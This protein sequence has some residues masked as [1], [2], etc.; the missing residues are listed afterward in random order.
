MK[1]LPDWQNLDVLH[2]G[3][4]EP[5][6][7]LIPYTCERAAIAGDRGASD[8][9]RLLNGEWDFCY[10]DKGVAPEGFQ[11]PDYELDAGWDTLPVPANWQMH[12][13]DIPQYANVNYPIP[14]DPPY[15]PDE[16]PV[17][18]Y[19]RWFTLPEGWSN[20]QVFLNFDGVNSAFYVWI[21]GS[22]VG[23]S[24]VAHMPAE[25]DITS[26]LVNGENLIAVMV[27]KW[28]DGSYLE[29]QDFWRLS[30]IFRDVYL[31]GA[32]KTHIRNLVAHAELDDTYTNGS[33]KLD[34]QAVNYGDKPAELTLKTKLLYK[35]RAV[36][37][38]EAPLPLTTDGPTALSLCIDVPGCKKWTAETPELYLL[39]AELWQDDQLIEVQRVDIGFRRVEIRDR[40]LFVNGVSIKIKGVNR[41]DTHSELGHVTPMEALLKDIELMKQNNVNTVR[42]SHY[43]ND[44]RWLELCDRY[45]LYVVDETDL[46]C[47]G[48]AMQSPTGYDA[49]AVNI[50][51]DDSKWEKAYV[52]RAE[53]MVCRDVNHPSI[54]I[55]SL[56]NES[57]YGCNHQAMRARILE[58]DASRP[59]HYEGEWAN[60]KMDEAHEWVSDIKSRMYPA[61]ETLAEEGVRPVE[62]DHRPYF[63]C[64][65]GHAMG[66]GPGSLKEYWD[67]IY[68]HDRLIGGCIWEW[69]D[70][71]ILTETEDGEAYYAYGGDFG[72]HP[73]DGCFCVDALNYPDRTP[74]TGLI[75]LKA[76]YAPV[77]FERVGANEIKI[78]NLFAF[79]TLDHLDAAWSLVCEGEQLACG[80]LDLS[81]VA[82][83]G[84]KVVKIDFE[85][86]ESGES[87]IEIRVNEAF[88]TLYCER[89][90][91]VASAQLMLDT[92]PEIYRI[93]AAAMGTLSMDEDDTHVEL[94]GEDFSV[95]FEKDTGRLVSW[96]SAGNEL[97]EK[98]P[99]VNLFRAYIDND[100][101]IRKSWDMLDLTRLLARVEN[102]HIERLNES[103][104]RIAVKRVYSPKIYAPILRAT[105]TYT[106]YGNGSIRLNTIF[107]PLRE[108]PYLP[109]VG[110]QL[111]M[112]AQFD[113]VLWYG[114]GPHENYPD[115][116]VSALLGQ[117]TAMVDDLHE[118]YVRPQ[119]NGARGG[120]RA[121]AVTDILGAGLMVVGEE[122]FE[123][124]G[125]SFSAHPYSDVA[126]HKATHTPELHAE[127][128]TVLS[129][130][131]RMGGVGSNS[132]GPEPQEK[133][134]LR[135]TE[136]ASFTLVLSP[137]NRQMGEMMNFAR[138]LPE[139][140]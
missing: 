69:V 18:C 42:T 60:K 78:R 66:L 86:P 112:P 139:N 90:H 36:K 98:G 2:I 11:L 118:P 1:Q 102:F 35:N 65:Y 43:P 127:E 107:E 39:L 56:G 50:L 75:E 77:R 113:R 17:G 89:G 25:F 70:H 94:L 129:L 45:G 62:E 51:S 38:T 81:G 85:M 57:G 68:A 115:L 37:E 24:K 131:W 20:R 28:S 122:T 87:F 83:Y 72:E 64:E 22:F 121:L 55:W 47:H 12:G 71:G 46:E 111:T 33:L 140:N 135:L 82:P 4:E 123:G 80:R 91:E 31:L 40:Q 92:K 104:V 44:P 19:R 114:K 16:N 76:I 119:E 53:R 10:A 13:Y 67:V 105:M 128:R 120:V 133:Y 97:I 30:G 106:V 132:C 84:E 117:Y 93:P 126:L 103:A 88:D 137:Y 136:K 109:R 7:S 63:M 116:G 21:N 108:L 52:D 125:F 49:G 5:R 95:L 73:H 34:V 9:Y 74:H 14:F 61:V 59:I 130:D 96:L 138:I 110:L 58:L 99:D 23:F 3:R 41:H 32:P 54:I 8:C 26:H 6:A 100:N 101:N 27:Y 124:N 48:C 15:V 134:R 79:R 29:D